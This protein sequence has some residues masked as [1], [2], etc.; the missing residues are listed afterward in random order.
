MPERRHGH[1]APR[2]PLFVV[3]KI[4]VGEPFDEDSRKSKFS[5]LKT[6]S[7]SHTFRMCKHSSFVNAAQSL[8]IF[9]KTSASESENRH[10][11]AI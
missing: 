5:T 9:R 10:D 6:A 8:R 1:C 2:R 4:V 3:H 7:S 11:S